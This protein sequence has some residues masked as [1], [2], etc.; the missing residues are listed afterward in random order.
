MA[1]STE[2]AFETTRV[3]Q[4]RE[5][6]MTSQVDQLTKQ[7]DEGEAQILIFEQMLADFK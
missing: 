7:R 1:E 6:A 4:E 3:Y 5:T 2:N